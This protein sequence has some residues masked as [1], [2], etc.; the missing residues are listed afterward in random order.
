MPVSI[1]ILHIT[2]LS[3]AALT[4]GC[5]PLPAG[6]PPASAPVRATAAH[7]TDETGPTAEGPLGSIPL[8]AAHSVALPPITLGDDYEAALAR[9]EAEGKPLLLFF[10]APW[11]EYSR[12]LEAEV[13][14]QADAQAAASRFVCVRIDVA[15]R[16]LHEQYRVKV[17]PTIIPAT[18]RGTAS[19][20]LTGAQTVESFVTGLTTALTAVTEPRPA[21][22][23]TIQR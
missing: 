12:R 6:T 5:G 7:R 4:A 17:F 8:A 3:A 16:D 23:T 15:R 10:T 22:E 21:A 11:C 14:N 1:R 2:L 9:A 13:L 20:R 19:Q 18:S